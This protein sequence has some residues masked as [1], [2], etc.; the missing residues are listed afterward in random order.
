MK[1]YHAKLFILLFFAIAI[2]SCNPEGGLKNPANYIDYVD[3]SRDLD[4][5]VSQDGNL[6][7]YYH[8]SL[9]YPEPEDYPTGLYV[10]NEEGTNRRLLLKGD[11]WSPSWS[12][13][14]EW[15]VF[16]SGGILQIINIEGDSIRTFQRI[17]D[18]PLYSP[19]WS[20]DG[21]EILFSAPLTIEGGVFKMTPDF[22]HIKRILDPQTN[23][24]MYASWSP[25]RNKIVYEKGSQTWKST[26]IF[27][28]DTLLVSEIRLTNNDRDDRDPTWSPIGN[29]IAWSSNMQIY[30]KH[31][32]GNDEYRF[33]YGRF[34]AWTPDSKYIIYCNA[35]DD[36]SKEVLYK[37]DINGEKKIQLTF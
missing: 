12:P 13:D 4:P 3:I 7:A 8:Q 36:F 33:D 17:D 28:I 35:N 32:D 9:E 1:N 31:I 23:N 37:I 5:A 27:I 6:I 22:I 30:I 21:K 19:D 18:L 24:G 11:H 34:P 25:G 29:M 20:R 15:L 10:M 14:G 26:D 2:I 16:T